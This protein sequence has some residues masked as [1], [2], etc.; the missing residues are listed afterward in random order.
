VVARRRATLGE[1]HLDVAT[2]SDALGRA[3]AE[4][5]AMA[6]ARPHLERALAIQARV[7][8]DADPRIV[9]TLATLARVRSET[10][11]CAG[12]VTDGERALAILDAARVAEDSDRIQ[13]LIAIV[14]CAPTRARFERLLALL[15]ASGAPADQ[16]VWARQMLSTFD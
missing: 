6:E 8:G 5:G 2:A 4:H 12:A 16:V 11:D 14:P 9:A 7:H 10:G 1:H 3:Y 13:A 15:E